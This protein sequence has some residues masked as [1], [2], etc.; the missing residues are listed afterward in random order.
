MATTDRHTEKLRTF[1][2]LAALVGAEFSAG[3]HERR[4]R[5][6]VGEGVLDTEAGQVLVLTVTRLLPRICERI[7]FHVPEAECAGRLRPLLASSTFSSESLE[8]LARLIW[9]GDFTAS[10]DY[11]ADATIGIGAPGDIAVGID[12]AGAAVVGHGEAIAIEM[13]DALEAALVAAALGCAETTKHLWPEIFGACEGVEVR[14]ASGP[15]GGTPEPVRP[16]VLERP[17][18]AGVGA[19]GCA[20]IYALIALGATGR[21]LLL[22]PDIVSDSNL[23]RYILFDSRHLKMAKT[24]AAE[25][26]IAATGLDLDVEYDKKVLQEYLKERPDERERLELV[27]SA[28]DTYQARREI[29]GELPHQVVNAG[30]TPS[31]F[32]VS[33][34]GFGD[35]YACLACLY[36]P[37]EVDIELAAVMAR[38]LGL[39]QTEVEQLRRTKKPTSAELLT[40][41]A[42]NRGL[43]PDY[44]ADFIGEPV[45]TVYNKIVCGGR[46]IE[47]ERGEAVAPL[48]YGAALA[49]FLLGRVVAEPGGEYRR[50]RMDF[51]RGLRTPIRSSPRA[52]ESCQY[53]GKSVF[54]RVYGERWAEPI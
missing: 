36:P 47:T 23:M 21:V 7:D 35:G 37:R 43:E 3:M 5:V 25:E 20:T 33:R 12:A 40:R 10:D 45:D 13:P 39:E 32:T 17:V 44:Y 27:V 6:D 22:D 31:D 11:M 42:T 34:H 9:D 15:F 46:P 4:L 30:T 38:E 18:V 24:Q 8:A 52:R 19:V 54:R 14:F 16:V 1:A 26:L 28:V 51:I 29:A 50:F 2:H 41:L 53:C 49:G 48:A